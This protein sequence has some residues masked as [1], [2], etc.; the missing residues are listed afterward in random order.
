MVQ[1]TVVDY[2]ADEKSEVQLGP[3]VSTLNGTIDDWVERDYGLKVFVT[4]PDE[5]VRD[6][7]NTIG[8]MEGFDLDD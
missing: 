4:I 2:N 7:K 1:F 8:D 3:L 6:F 5:N